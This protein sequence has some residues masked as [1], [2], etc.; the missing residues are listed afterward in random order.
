[1]DIAEI[2]REV[3]ARNASDLHLAVGV[4]PVVRIDGHLQNLD[5]PNDRRHTH[6]QMQVGRIPRYDFSKDRKSVV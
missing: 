6:R 5:Y 1:M 4:P 3:I 2:L